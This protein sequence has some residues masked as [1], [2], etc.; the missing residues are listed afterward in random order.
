[1]TARLASYH[2]ACSAVTLQLAVH[3]LSV[4]T[5]RMP[6]QR[7]EAAIAAAPTSASRHVRSREM[8]QARIRGYLTPSE[9]TPVS[10]FLTGP[11][12]AQGL[13]FFV[14]LDAFVAEMVT[15]HDA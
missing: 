8:K 9:Y 4:A 1:L 3:Y 11:D 6:C 2:I 10:I 7:P 13:R 5:N 15:V 14:M 12:C